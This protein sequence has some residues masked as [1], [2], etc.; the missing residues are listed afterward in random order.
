VT[1]QLITVLGMTCGIWQM[2]PL[3]RSYVEAWSP[4]P[5]DQPN[6][7]TIS[8]RKPIA[9]PL[10]VDP[11]DLQTIFAPALAKS[12]ASGVA[13][14]RR[15]CR[16]A[17]PCRHN[18]GSPAAHSKQMRAKQPA[19]KYP[20]ISDEFDDPRSLHAKVFDIECRDG[21]LLISGSANA[22]LPALAGGN[23]EAVVARIV[24]PT[25]SLGW[26]AMGEVMLPTVAGDTG[27]DFEWR[28]CLAARFNGEIVEGLLFGQEH[29]EGEWT[30]ALRCGSRTERLRH[31]VNV[32]GTGA[33]RFLP[34][35]SDMTGFPSS[36]QL[37]LERDGVEVRG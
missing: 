7:L 16:N 11:L 15:R 28:P 21:R 10:W 1:Q 26:R 5:G 23:I 37:V 34:E 32:A 29:P 22:T 13:P 27:H 19:D 17:S 35:A 2:R 20:V 18:S 3:V 4:R 33:F 12:E 24:E 25:R 9:V 31:A 8:L 14:G 36:T 30:G 6:I